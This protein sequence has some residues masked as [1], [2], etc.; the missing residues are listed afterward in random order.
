MK[1]RQLGTTGIEVSGF[2]LG[3]W[4]FSGGEPFGEQDDGDS[5]A[6]VN[7]ALENGVNFIDTAEGYGAG[8]AEAVLGRALGGR[9]KDVVIT[10]KVA[11]VHLLPEQVQ[12]ACEGQPGK[13]R[14]R[15][16]RP[17]PHPLAKPGGPARRHGRHTRASEAGRQDPVFRSLQFR[18]PGPV[19]HTAAYKASK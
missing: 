17:L 18:R 5:I 10:S 15:L 8:R 7:A 4:P 1:Y 6:A 16:H 14:H 3:T 19:R 2:T 13:A 11:E 12:E 9:R